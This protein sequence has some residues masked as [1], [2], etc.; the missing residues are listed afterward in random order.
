MRSR[1]DAITAAL[2]FALMLPSRAASLVYDTITVQV[3]V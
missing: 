1:E 2:S 3:S